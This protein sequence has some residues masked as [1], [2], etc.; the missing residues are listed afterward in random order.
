MGNRCPAGAQYG[1]P[2]VAWFA[3]KRLGGNGA[4]L[5]GEHRQGWA[6]Q[7]HGRTVR[8]RERQEHAALA[9][10][11]GLLVQSIDFTLR[12]SHFDHPPEAL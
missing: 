3:G 1:A 10:G 7:V 4:E 8:R 6:G 11:L 12:V 2:V 9:P 5:P